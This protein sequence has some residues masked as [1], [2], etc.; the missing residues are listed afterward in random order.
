LKADGTREWN[1][2]LDINF[3]MYEFPKLG[4]VIIKRED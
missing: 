2:S 4:E 1:Y 3:G